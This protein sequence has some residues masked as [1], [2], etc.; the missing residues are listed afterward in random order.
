M[1]EKS[2][3]PVQPRGIAMPEPSDRRLIVAAGRGDGAA[4]AR[5]YRRHRDVLLAF[6]LARTGDAALAA[7]LAAESFAVALTAC[8]RY[9][10]DA[11]PPSWLFAI[12]RRLLTESRRR[13]TVDDHARRRL[14]LARLELDDGDLERIARLRELLPDGFPP[15]G[16]LEGLTEALREALRA[17]ALDE[18]EHSRATPGLRGSPAVARSDRAP[19][20]IPSGGAER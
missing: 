16:Q 6:F 10:P 9:R 15:P 13:G 2:A 14:G 7:D 12:A 5:L 20:P 4:F 19:E 11:P 3:D 1:S 8:H 18:L 17:R